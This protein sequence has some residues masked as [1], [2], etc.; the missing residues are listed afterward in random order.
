MK[1]YHSLFLLILISM[2]FTVTAQFK[3]GTVLLETNFGDIS[4]GKSNYEYESTSSTTTREDK[5]SNISFYPRVGFFVSNNLVLGTA[6]TL[7]FSSNKADNFDVAGKKTTDAKSATSNIGVA[8]FIRYYFNSFSN[9]WSRFY[10]QLAGG[11]STDLSSKYES[12]SYTTTGALATIFTY[13]YPKRYFGYN[14]SFL[15]GYNNMIAKNV[16]LN[17]NLGYKYSGYNYDLGY[18]TTTPAGITTPGPVLKYLNKTGSIEW[19]VGVSI[20]IPR[21][22]KKK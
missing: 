21:T 6:L 18:S 2:T 20:L 11:I 13:D 22:K 10:L 14:A 4:V 9:S 8:P 15:L 12:R 5:F 19:G 1:K 17:L 16:A 3:K 7:S